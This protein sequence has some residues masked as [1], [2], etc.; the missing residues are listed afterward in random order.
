[1][2][3]PVIKSRTA[4]PT[5]YTFKVA[6]CASSTTRFNVRSCSGDSRLSSM[7]M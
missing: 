6:A 3:D 2:G 7:K 4:P 5:R 1:M